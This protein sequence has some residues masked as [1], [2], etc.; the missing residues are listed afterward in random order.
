MCQPHSAHTRG[1]ACYIGQIFER[2]ATL[3]ATYC[4]V[5]C[6][7]VLF[8]RCLSVRFLHPPAACAGTPQPTCCCAAQ[9]QAALPSGPTQCQQT[10]KQQALLG[11][12]TC[13]T[14]AQPGLLTRTICR[15]HLTSECGEQGSELACACLSNG[16]GRNV[17][18]LLWHCRESSHCCLVKRLQRPQPAQPLQVNRR[19]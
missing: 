10:C 14:T 7:L 1:A 18:L 8:Y 15:Q 12:T 13:S 9:Q 11:R 5:L 19:D 17:S 16:L 2:G 6:N 4:I 3:N